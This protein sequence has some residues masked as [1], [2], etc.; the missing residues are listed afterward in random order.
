MLLET[1]RCLIRPF[2]PDDASALWEIL[3]DPE[4]MRFIEPVF[5]LEKTKLFLQ[6]AGMCTPPLVYALIHKACNRLIGQVIFHPFGED[7]YEIGWLLHRD[8]W[9]HG[10]ADEVTKALMAHAKSMGISSC[11]IE[12]SCRQ[13]ASRHI[14]LKNGFRCISTEDEL[15]TYHLAL[16]L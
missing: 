3:G 4:V 11:I 6:Q 2:C 5:S 16:N 9:G 1:A 13:E 10:I 14:A 8:Y 7:A 12:C 15:E